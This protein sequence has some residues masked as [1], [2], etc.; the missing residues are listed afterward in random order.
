MAVNT[1]MYEKVLERYVRH[2]PLALLT[3]TDYESIMIVEELLPYSIGIEIECNSGSNPN[4]QRFK[5]IPNI[6]YVDATS[7]PNIESEHRFRIPKGINGVMC[8][9]NIC[10]QLKVLCRTNPQS[11]IHYHVDMTDCYSFLTVD[12][13][14]THSEWMLQQLDHWEYKGT[15]N[16]R[17]ICG[18]G[19]SNGAWIRFQDGFKTAEIRI[20]EM[21]FEY[22][23][24]ITRIIDC[25][26]IIKKLKSFLP[27]L[28][29]EAPKFN[30]KEWI[31][32]LS[33]SLSSIEIEDKIKAIRKKL[34][35]INFSGIAAT[36]S[37]LTQTL[38]LQEANKVVKSRVKKIGIKK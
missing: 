21:S 27:T 16:S 25:C 23:V 26:R 28:Y 13:I 24:L 14:K 3:V 22:E 33:L 18:K 15:Y 31:E 4:P 20:G 2:T 5:A 9:Y 10:E 17:G 6:L 11:G 7:T 1:E 32:Y 8:L 35:E 38:S 12:L 37:I 19:L 34:G 30:P 29:T 36:D